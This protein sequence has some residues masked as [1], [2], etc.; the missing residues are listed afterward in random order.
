MAGQLDLSIHKYNIIYFQ[1]MDIKEK[2]AGVASATTAAMSS[3]KKAAT[4]MT[5]LS[6]VI[7]PRIPEIP[8]VSGMPEAINEQAST[9]YAAIMGNTGFDKSSEQY[10]A[11]AEILK[12]ENLYN[13][14]GKRFDN[15]TMELAANLSFWFSSFDKS[16]DNKSAE[17]I[18]ESLCKAID[19]L[20]T[21]LQN[22]P[23][24]K[25]YEFQFALPS[26]KKIPQSTFCKKD[27]VLI[28]ED[29]ID[30][31]IEL[32]KELYPNVT[33]LKRLTKTNPDMIHYR[34]FQP[35]TYDI[36]PLDLKFDSNTGKYRELN[37]PQ[38]QPIPSA[39]P[40]PAP[41]HGGHYEGHGGHYEGHGGHYEG[42]GEHYEGHGGHYEGHEGH[43]VGGAGNYYK[44][45]LTDLKIAEYKN[46]ENQIKSTLDRIQ[47]H[48]IYSPKFEELFISDR[49]MMVVI[50]FVLRNLTLYL[51]EWGINSTFINTF[52]SA[53]DYFILIY[54][55]LFLLIVCAVNN[56][57]IKNISL[58][59]L[60]YYLNIEANGAFRIIIHLL[61]MV[62]LYPIV[63]IFKNKNP[64]NKIISYDDRNSIKNVLET[65]TFIIW[66]I[67][68]IIILRF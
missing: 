39:P 62:F 64:D 26:G 9:F 10:K 8:D 48:P 15:D 4:N 40:A 20:N 19:K 13:L 57:M 18:K 33:H 44:D 23:I 32:V 59:M 34:S 42:H 7:R 47:N 68:S 27:P 35:E 38:P 55:L 52:K 61:I 45:A 11:L 28:G 2:A 41:P 53:F 1:V 12:A 25:E 21:N 29:V 50:A 30:N 17:E 43:Y 6:G 54:S 31:N 56:N 14:F 51:V 46:D 60:I 16:I 58:K 63:I 66:L 3:I 36:K 24:A 37:Q 22:N 67:Q 49:F 5:P 65:I